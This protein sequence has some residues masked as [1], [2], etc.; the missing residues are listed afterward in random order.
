MGRADVASA[1]FSLTQAGDLPALGQARRSRWASD[2]PSAV[3]VIVVAAL[4]EVEVTAVR[5]H[6]TG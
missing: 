1:T 4:V 2:I 3:T 6:K 5:P